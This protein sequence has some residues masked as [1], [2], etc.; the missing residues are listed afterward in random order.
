MKFIFI[1][2]LS[3][4]QTFSYFNIIFIKIDES[5]VKNNLLNIIKKIS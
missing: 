1:K 4:I 3:L 5:F 2:K